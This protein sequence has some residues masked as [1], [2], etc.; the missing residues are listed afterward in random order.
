MR[1][2]WDYTQSCSV[3]WCIARVPMSVICHDPLRR[4]VVTHR[5]RSDP[6]YDGNRVVWGRSKHRKKSQPGVTFW[7]CSIISERLPVVSYRNRS[8]ASHDK[9]HLWLWCLLENFAHNYVINPR[10][11]IKTLSETLDQAGKKVFRYTAYQSC[12]EEISIDAG[13]W[14]HRCLEI[15][16]I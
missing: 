13:P 4:P 14:R 5:V 6:S 2:L 15:I 10:T 7:T 9:T 8:H 1:K 12:T 3:R 11:T 16:I